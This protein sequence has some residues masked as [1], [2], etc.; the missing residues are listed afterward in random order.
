MMLEAPARAWP[1]RRAKLVAYWLSSF[2][3]KHI[4]L[5]IVLAAL[6]VHGSL[7]IA[8]LTGLAFQ[9]GKVVTVFVRIP[10][11]PGLAAVAAVTGTALLLCDDGGRLPSLIGT[12]VIALATNYTRQW[13]KRDLGHVERVKNSARICA[14]LSAPFFSVVVTGVVTIGAVVM[15][16]R[17]VERGR[18]TDTR[19]TAGIVGRARPNHVAMMLHHAHYFSYSHAVSFL[20]LCVFGAPAAALGVVFYL[21]WI[22]Y[23]VYDFVAVRSSAPRFA[24]GHVIAAVG[25]VGLFWTDSA[26]VALLWWTATGI[27]G[28]TF[29]M[30]ADLRS[31]DDRDSAWNLEVVEYYGHLAG[32]V[33]LVAMAAVASLATVGVVAGLLALAAPLSLAWRS[34]PDRMERVLPAIVPKEIV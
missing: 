21:G 33:L 1:D 15:L 13:A 22:G 34:L 17:G 3:E 27:G 19:I 32:M 23:E 25:I 29:V 2:A 9:V 8:A 26:L 12:A 6:A 10:P 14:V 4:E 30:L 20:F 18:L 31:R 16:S 5:G 24:A 28:G 7:L 11:A